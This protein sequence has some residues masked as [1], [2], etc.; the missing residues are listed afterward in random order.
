MPN[1][2]Q[3]ILQGGNN[4]MYTQGQPQGYPPQQQGGYPPQQPGYPPPQQGYPPPQPQQPGYPQPQQPGYPPPQQGAGGGYPPPQQGAGG[5]PA[6]PQGSYQGAPGGPQGTD[7]PSYKGDIPDD[8]VEVNPDNAAG[9]APIASAPPLEK[10]DQVAG[11]NQMDAPLPPPPPPSYD[12]A[13]QPTERAGIEQTPTLTDEEAREALLSY[14]AENCCYGKKA[15]KNLH[16]ND[17]KHTAAFHYTLE[18]FTEKRTTKWVNEPFS[19]QPVD[20]PQNGPAP[21][22]WSIAVNIPAMFTNSIA[23]VEV[24]HTASVKPCHDCHSMGFRRCHTCL[25]RGRTRCH[26]C[27]GHGRRHVNHYDH[28]EKR[29]ISRWESCTFCHGRGRQRCFTC[30]GHGQITCCTCKGRG[31]LKFF[32]QLTVNWI[33][34][35]NDNIVERTA[36][37]DELIRNVTG[38]VA[39]KEENAR[40]WPINHFPDQ[41]INQASRE[42]VQQHSG[43]FQQE[44]ILQQRHQVRIIPVAESL[45][46]W[47]EKNFSFF[48]YGFERKVH[49][50]DYPQQ[51]C[52]GCT[53]L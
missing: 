43:A 7:E 27:H 25:G 14:V 15:A 10:M 35:M 33:N 28:H 4:T 38:Q 8:D 20:G 2:T 18:T 13:T 29:H 21:L 17:L 32:I 41:A 11:Y 30:H 22:P 51:C 49:A 26:H 6:P 48:V 12:E 3:P 34:H 44:R 53:I 46:R 52:C 9:A 1:E 37:P 42:L 47:K 45:C 16:V 39:F 24:P 19:G 40:I 23:K 31:S 5:Y 50:P 36:L